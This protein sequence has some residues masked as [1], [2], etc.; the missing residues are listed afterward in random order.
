M[1]FKSIRQKLVSSI[2]ALFALSFVATLSVVA[3]LKLV[4]AERT[5]IKVEEGIRKSMVGRGTTLVVNNSQALVGMVDDNA[6]S[7]VAQLVS[8]TVANDSAID[9]GI[10]MDTDRRPWVNARAENPQGLVSPGEVLDDEVSRW[11]AELREFEINIHVRD[12]IE[13]YEFV[14][15]VVIDDDVLGFVRYGFS[16]T[17][18]YQW[19]RAE[20]QEAQRELMW[21]LGMILVMGV[22]AVLLG[23]VVV[24]KIARRITTP[25]NSLQTAA[26]RIA[27]GDY[28]DAVSVATNDEIGVL[29]G[30]FEVMRATINRKMLDLATLNARG[31]ELASMQRQSVALERVLRAMEE[32]F[33]VAFGSIYLADDKGIFSLRECYPKEAHLPERT[34]LA[35]SLGEGV[36]GAA[37]QMKDI[38]FVPD[39]ANDARF[40]HPSGE[41]HAIALLCVPLLDEDQ[42]IGVMNLS[43]EVGSVNFEDADREFTASLA[44]LLT[45]T[46][47]NIRMREIIEEQNRNLEH[48]VEQRTAELREKSNDIVNMLQNMHQG[49]FTIMQ[50]GCVHHEYARYLEKILDTGEVAGRP[51][52]DLLFADTDL[53]GDRL[54]Q[55]RVAV[56]SMLGC[57]EMA[58][59]F[60]AHLLPR[61]LRIHQR[62]VKVLELDWDPIIFNGEI[63]KIMVAV[64]DVTSLR[65]LQ[66]EAANQRQELEIIGEILAVERSKFDDFIS[67]TH[68]LVAECRDIVEAMTRA[69]ADAIAPLFRNM[70]T[71]KGNART[72]GFAHITRVVHEVEQVYDDL[73]KDTGRRWDRA[74]LLYDLDRVEHALARYD[75]ISR[76]KLGRG[77]KNAQRVPEARNFSNTD[78]LLE[79]IDQMNF[80]GLDAETQS[81]WAELYVMLAQSEAQTLDSII[82]DVIDATSS[83]AAE[84]GKPA[85]NIAFGGVR[86]YIRKSAHGLLENVFTHVLRN[87]IDHGIEGPQ[88]RRQRDKPEAG[89]ISI[90]LA[91]APGGVIVKIADDGRGLAM[92][93]LLE[94]GRA[95]GIFA[96]DETPEET[97]IA[98]LIFHS[99]LST[100]GAVS[101]ISGRGVGMDAVKNFLAQSDAT[102]RV[103]LTDDGDGREFRPFVLELSLPK[104]FCVDLP[105]GIQTQVA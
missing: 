88:E 4:E 31:E 51:F 48:K 25:L 1:K 63:D 54:E 75:A 86:P 24:R 27:A 64:R 94:K 97:A 53:G 9:Y 43:G 80:A 15:P 68:R 47:N 40:I 16:T 57:D 99:G 81:L 77:M 93:A 46:L 103:V 7:A 55:I 105:T 59:A 73:R 90:N 38:V 89:S 67:G 29:A 23:T 35:F 2:S 42:L 36:L 83:I 21:A 87:C 92:Q 6:F 78:Q 104:K 66:A 5:L 58:F 65:A 98:N 19:L 39:S 20:S 62:E 18:M 61:E 32:R 82:A 85:P 44:R 60:N 56:E 17:R 37:A 101:E 76:E 71:V 49:L 41:G 34:P 95:A 69:D 3:G 26:A 30:Q 11:A 100:A 28:Q 84:L 74:S 12:G 22:I 14:S 70:H 102:I 45:I 91:T 50:N 52:M 10:F 13:I 79:K 72:H 8:T 33:G 96:A